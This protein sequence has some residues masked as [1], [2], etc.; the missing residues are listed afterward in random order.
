MKYKNRN[1]EPGG[2]PLPAGQPLQIG[3]MV[4]PGPTS[5]MQLEL[6]TIARN[7]ESGRGNAVS[8]PY[9]APGSR[10]N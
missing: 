4:S 7:L 2:V 10:D 1:L 6:D 9:P 8:K 3:S 5:G